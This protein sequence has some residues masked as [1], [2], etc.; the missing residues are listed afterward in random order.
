MLSY[1]SQDQSGK[2]QRHGDCAT[3]TANMSLHVLAQI[4]HALLGHLNT[5]SIK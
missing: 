2:Q 4:T 3:L 1:F 5:H